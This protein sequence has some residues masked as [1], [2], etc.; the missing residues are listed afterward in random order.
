M[1]NKKCILALVIILDALIIVLGLIYINLP[2]VYFDSAI[3]DYIASTL[4]HP[5]V[6]NQTGMMMSHVGIPLIGNI[7]Y[8]TLSMFAQIAVLQLFRGTVFTLRIT[9]LLYVVLCADLIFLIIYR[10]VGKFWIG[11]CG[12]LL[13]G[14]SISVLTLTRTQYDIMLP[15]ACFFLLSIIFLEKIITSKDDDHLALAKLFYL[16]GLFLGVSFYDYFCFLFFVPVIVFVAIK[17][18][19][20]HLVYMMISSIWGFLCGCSLY[21]CGFADSFITNALGNTRLAFI[22]LMIFSTLFYAA[23]AVPSFYFLRKKAV[24]H[25][26]WKTYV[27]LAGVVFVAAIGIAVV[28]SQLLISKINSFSLGGV[29][30]RKTGSKTAFITHFFTLYYSLIS[31]QAAESQINGVCTSIFGRLYFLIFL[32]ITIVLVIMMIIKRE[33][34]KAR[35]FIFWM[36]SFYLSFYICSIPLI[37][38]MQEQH[39]VP[40]LFLTFPYIV[41]SVW[42]LA[43]ELKNMRYLAVGIL[44]TVFVI[45][46]LVDTYSFYHEL[47]L[48]RGVGAYSEELNLLFE[49]AYDR[50]LNE[51]DVYFLVNPGV[52][53]SFVYLT[54]NN[55]K[56][57]LLY[58]IDGN[59]DLD[60]VSLIDEYLSDGYN[61][62]LL[63][64][65][66]DLDETIDELNRNNG[67]VA[68]NKR[69]SQDTRGALV[70]SIAEIKE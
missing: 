44:S 60:K 65:Y 46:N 37:S 29:E 14:T 39:M 69:N 54:D 25:I 47:N 68:E 36:M 45:M 2:G 30:S 12:L 61:V 5:Q 18:N 48:T 58:S 67:M 53:P 17:H 21:F 6:D 23:L 56:V 57:E 15:G 63:S 26:I 55:I 16:M 27:I 11:M 24:P 1:N 66:Y 32:V 51:K 33:R 49:E 41:I 64:V 28:C 42:Y 20:H 13:C 4:V 9:Y 19:G 40:L 7:Y 59:F 34:N 70:Y 43:R 38:G 62:F 3:T 52:L 22:V 50:S 8:G 10:L 35:D 31:G